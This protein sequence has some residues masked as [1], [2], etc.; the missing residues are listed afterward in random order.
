MRS[1]KRQAAAQGL[2]L[3]HSDYGY[4][5]IDSARK[6]VDDRNDMT[7]AEVESWLGRA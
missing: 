4:A 3:R 1:L 5:L 7:L 6:P 2:Q